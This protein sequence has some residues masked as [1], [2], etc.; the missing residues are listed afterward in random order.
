MKAMVVQRNEYQDREER[1]RLTRLVSQTRWALARSIALRRIRCTVAKPPTINWHRPLSMDT[2][3]DVETG[4]CT[5][6]A[7]TGHMKQN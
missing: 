2:G 3:H 1:A 5:L 6:Q 7:L 4:A